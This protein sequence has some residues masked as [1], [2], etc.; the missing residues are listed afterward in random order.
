MCVRVGACVLD[1]RSVTNSGENV[2]V[3][4]GESLTLLLI[5]LLQHHIVVNTQTL[6]NVKK[7]K[8]KNWSA[9]RADKQKV[10]EK[11]DGERMGGAKVRK[12]M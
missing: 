8:K 12:F 6:F 10:Y 2:E 5:L 1:V 4:Q 3:M 7:R 9:D 11:N